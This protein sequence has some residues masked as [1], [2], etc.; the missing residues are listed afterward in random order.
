[1]STIKRII[2]SETKDTTKIE[3]LKG[4]IPELKKMAFADYY[5]VLLREWLSFVGALAIGALIGVSLIFLVL[6]RLNL[7]PNLR[8]HTSIF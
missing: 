3:K 6:L 2:M 1:L 4:L 5:R 8:V 7:L